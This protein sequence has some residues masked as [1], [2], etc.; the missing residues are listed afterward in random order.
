MEP[1]PDLAALYQAFARVGAEQEFRRLHAWHK[2]KGRRNKR[3]FAK[4]LVKWLRDNA[5][6]H[7]NAPKRS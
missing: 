2:Q 6:L 7:P 4:S 3:L 5:A 1:I